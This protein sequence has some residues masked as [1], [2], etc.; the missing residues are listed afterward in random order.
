MQIK[1]TIRY[2]LTWITMAIIKMSTNA[3]EGVVKKEPF[4]IV[5]GNIN[6]YNHYGKHHGA[7]STKLKT[8]VPTVTQQVKN[9]TQ[10]P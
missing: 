7:S 2:H 8:G 9:P 3:G 6:W 5:G 10:C 1:T 4:H